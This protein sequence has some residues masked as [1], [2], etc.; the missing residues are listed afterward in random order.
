METQK[1][2][3]TSKWMVEERFIFTIFMMSRVKHPNEPPKTQPVGCGLLLVLETAVLGIDLALLEKV[4]FCIKTCGK[5]VFGS[6]GD[7]V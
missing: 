6:H 2:N 7:K 4:Q 5:T 1:S 3:V